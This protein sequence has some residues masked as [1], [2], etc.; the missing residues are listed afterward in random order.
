MFQGNDRRLQEMAAARRALAPV[1]QDPT[2]P[3]GCLECNAPAT[4]KHT[5]MVSGDISFWCNS[6]WD[7]WWIMTTVPALRQ[8]GRITHISDA[9]V[10]RGRDPETEDDSWVEWVN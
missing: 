4:T 3:V 10:P 9:I 7:F 2:Y 8:L 5:D 1:P 6:C